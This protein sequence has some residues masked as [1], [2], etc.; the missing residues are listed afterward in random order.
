MGYST[1]WTMWKTALDLKTCLSC[2]MNH[3][4]IYDINEF[5]F[6]E[7]P[8]HLRCRCII[9]RI[10]KHFLPVQQP[11]TKMG[12]YQMH[13]TEFGMRQIS[14]IIPAIEG[15]KEYCFQTMD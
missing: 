10:W 2:R 5:I 12:T 15:R 3:G 1:K 4:K 8:L 13:Q 14:T 11:K 6:P 7:P 9:E